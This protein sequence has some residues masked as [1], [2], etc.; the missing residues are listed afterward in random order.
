MFIK[1]DTVLI[2]PDG[3]QVTYFD[4]IGRYI[5]KLYRVLSQKYI[6][7]NINTATLNMKLR[8]QQLQKTE[9]LKSGNCRLMKSMH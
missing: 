8:E 5:S 9:A 2:C 1:G 3:D 7:S 6:Q 4:N